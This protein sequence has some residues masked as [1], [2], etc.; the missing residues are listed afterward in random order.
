MTVLSNARIVLADDVIAGSVVIEG[1]RIAAINP[2]AGPSGTDLDGDFLIPGLVD[3]HTD[4]LER[5]V[6]PRSTARWPSRSAL[7]AHDAQCAAAGITTVFDALCLGDSGFEE[8]RVRTFRDG[9]AD[10][11]AMAGTGLLKA[12]H[13]LHLR[14]ELPAPEMPELLDQAIDDPLVRL[15][16][17]MDHS[18][19]VGQY[20]DIGRYHRMRQA[21]GF[22]DGQ[23]DEMVGL[24]QRKRITYHQ[25]GRQL[26][27]ELTRERQIP[28]A[29]HDDRTAEEVAQNHRD[30][31]TISE[32][33]VSLEAAR[34]A[35]QSGIHIIAGAANIVRGG[36]HSGNVAALDLVRAGLVDALASDY[37]PAA[38]LEAAFRCAEQGALALPDAIALV[39]AGPATLAGLTNRGQIGPNLRADLVRVH[40]HGTLPVIRAVWRQGERVA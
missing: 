9:V 16:S 37:V 6:Q 26:V 10:L 31:I 18:P 3:L 8:G 2:G 19:G 5:Q 12:E 17:L 29:S 38:M 23:I 21:E 13:F 36:S 14:C 35:R 15:V 11:R 20:A 32:F 39:S 27:L 1:G 24:M 25:A 7:M 34:A 30:G 22:S 28:L 40:L 33:P 4:N